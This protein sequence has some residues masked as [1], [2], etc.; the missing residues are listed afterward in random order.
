M[1]DRRPRKLKKVLKAR[2]SLLLAMRVASLATISAIT[3]K[4]VVRMSSIVFPDDESKS[5]AISKLLENHNH[6]VNEIFKE[7]PQN[8]R[9]L[10][11]YRRNSENEIGE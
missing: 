10:E 11:V 9:E 7:G 4:Y 2:Y 6:E 1:K 5:S 3:S 8:W